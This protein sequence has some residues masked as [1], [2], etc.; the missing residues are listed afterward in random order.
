MAIELAARIPGGIAK[1]LTESEADLTATMKL[2]G[3]DP[4]A[5]ATRT[6]KTGKR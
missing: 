6:A 2:A 5:I 3:L 4:K 1:G